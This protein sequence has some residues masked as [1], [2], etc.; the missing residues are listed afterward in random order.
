MQNANDGQGKKDISRCFK[1]ASIVTRVKEQLSHKQMLVIVDTF[2][3][4]A[5]DPETP[6]KNAVQLVEVAEG[7]RQLA[8]TVGREWAPPE[9]EKLSTIGFIARECEKLRGLQEASSQ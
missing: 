7:M 2:H 9:P 3:E 5:I 4:W 8:E 1:D 6:S